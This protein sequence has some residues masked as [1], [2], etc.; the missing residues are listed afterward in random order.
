MKKIAENAD[1]VSMGALETPEFMA[2]KIDEFGGPE[3]YN[4]F[5]VGWAWAMETVM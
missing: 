5:A 2:S 4:H 1:K 3:S